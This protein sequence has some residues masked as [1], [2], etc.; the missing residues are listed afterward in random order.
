MLAHAAGTGAGGIAGLRQEAIDYAME[1][2]AVVFA[3]ARQ[4][5]DLR[6]M[7][8]REVGAHLDDDAAVLEID[9]ERVFLVHGHSLTSAAT[10]T[11]IILSG[12]AAT[13]PDPGAPFLILSTQ[14]MPDTT[15]PHSVYWPSR[16]FESLKTMKNWLRALLGSEVRAIET[17]PRTCGCLLNSAGS[18]SPMPP[19]PVPVGSP[20]WAMKPS[21]TRWKTPPAYLPSRA[22]FLIWA[23][24]L[25]ARSGR[26]WM[27]T[28]EL[29]LRSM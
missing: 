6:H 24:G 19:V 10:R 27:T 3:F 17:A 28:G 23:T 29:S 22:S 9:V 13:A 21:I 25:G 12:G 18:V 20:V 5:L 7:G 11:L 1:D 15:L 16:K 26:I 8:G 14:S 4:L 2:D